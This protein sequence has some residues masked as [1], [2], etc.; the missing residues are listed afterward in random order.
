MRINDLSEKAR[1]TL[2]KI[3]KARGVS[4]VEVLRYIAA[5]SSGRKVSKHS[6]LFSCSRGV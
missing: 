6:M 2:A 1:E 5:I 4:Q 3:A